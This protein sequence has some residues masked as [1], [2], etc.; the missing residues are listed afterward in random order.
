MTTVRFVGDLPLWAGTLLAL[1]AGLVVWRYYRRES[2]DLPNRLRWLLPLL[3]AAAFFVAVMTL[4]GP[5]L[6]HRQI[7]GQLGRV[8]IYLD[9]SQSMDVTDDHMPTARKLLVAQQ[10]GWLPPGEVDMSLWEMAEQLANA[11]RDVATRLASPSADADPVDEC[12]TSFVQALA[13]VAD[14]IHRY[15]WA[16]L[17]DLEEDPTV[18]RW[19]EMDARFHEELLLP[20]Q[21]LAEQPM[22]AADAREDAVTRLT[23]LCDAAASFEETLWNAFDR[24][25]WQLAASGNPSITS[26]LALFE[27][28]S[29]WRRAE[30]NLLD[31]SSGL[32][33]EL[34]HSHDVQLM[35]LSGP[36]AERLWDQHASPEVPAE[37]DVEPS[38]PSTDLGSGLADETTARAGNASDSD[39]QAESVQR[40][41]VVLISDGR[42][43]RGESPVQTA[44]RLGGQAIPVYAVGYGGWREP[45][46][47]AVLEIEHPDM[48]F[49]KDRIRGAIVVKDQMPRGQSFVVQIAHEDDTLW[50]QQ[51]TTQDVPLRRIDFEFSIDELVERLRTR[52]DSQIHHHALPLALRVS[53]VP[54]EGETETSNNVSTM[55]FTAITQSYRL[56]LIDGRSR[57]ETR[58]LRNVLE[59]D[60]QWD[61]DTILVG[62]STD[63]AAL[64]RGEGSDMFPTDRKALFDYDLLVLG[65]IPPAT[66]ADY[67]LNWIRDFVEMRGGGIVF[68]DGQRGHLRALDNETTGPLLPVSWLPGG[69]ESLPTRL[70]LTDAGGNQSALMLESSRLAN[71]RFWEELPAPHQIVPV[72]ALAGTEVFVEAVIGEK[73][74]PAIV[75]RSFGAGRVVYFAFDETWRWRYKAADTYHQRFWNQLVKWAMQR[76]FAVSDEF[77][78]LDSGPPSYREGDTADIRVRLR[79]LDGR[80][81]SDATVDA[82]LWQDGRIASTVSLAPAGAGNG[83]YRGRSGRLAGGEYEV[84]A[85]AAGYSIDALKARTQFTVLPPKSGEMQQVACNVELLR[86]MGLASGGRFLREEQVGELPELLRPL[87]SG[88]VVESDTLLWQSYWWFAAIVGLLAVEWMLR[89]RAGLL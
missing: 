42:H 15:E 67:E 81:A 74:Y 57:W 26:A 70:Q 4:T 11:R 40:T 73:R 88:R 68:I 36:E 69:I 23:Q 24:Y 43:N 13:I 47:L 6:H 45:P 31:S 66:L 85:R 32:L 51:L 27:K 72:Q 12:R 53:I 5:V 59:R 78:S 10:Q 14:A 60:E 35:G 49:Q 54:L 46:D 82:I 56:L 37:L 8:L 9:T 7:I 44:R 79:G 18:A 55:R 61:I 1:A 3:R 22:D 16:T 34:S 87:S 52:F 28:T 76:P 65:E 75:T 25:G 50:Q 38:R 29:R 80:P 48:V 19:E 33:V 41:A 21:T 30:N 89:K 64:P 84:S 39:P 63:D 86:E 62:P 58:Y 20:A 77:V 83:I 2:H 17:S 71:E